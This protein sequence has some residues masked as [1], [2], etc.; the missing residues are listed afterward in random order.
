MALCLNCLWS[1]EEYCPGDL[2]SIIIA[3]SHIRGLEIAENSENFGVQFVCV[4]HNDVRWSKIPNSKEKYGKK[5]LPSALLTNGRVLFS[6]SI[7]NCKISEFFHGGCML[8]FQL[9]QYIAPS[10]K[11]LSCS[12]SYYLLINLSPKFVGDD[13]VLPFQIVSGSSTTSNEI[14]L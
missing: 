14:F 12:I 1:K 10:F 4:Y 7:E 8:Q 11:G 2:I 5:V 9:P 13:I 3:I 6:T